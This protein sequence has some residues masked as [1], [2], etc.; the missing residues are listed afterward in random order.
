[1]PLTKSVLRTDRLLLF[2]DLAGTLVF[3]IEG[4]SRAAQNRK[5]KLAV[6]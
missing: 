4:A 5:T 1:M 3:A 2:V 6:T